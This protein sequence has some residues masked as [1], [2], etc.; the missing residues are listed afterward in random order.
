MEIDSVIEAEEGTKKH[1]VIWISHEAE[2]GT[3]CTLKLSPRDTSVHALVSSSGF[4]FW[5][6]V[7]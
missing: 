7:I 1:L 3:E 4:C 2:I 6:V 5:N